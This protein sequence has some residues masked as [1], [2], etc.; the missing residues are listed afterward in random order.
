MKH[1]TVNHKNRFTYFFVRDEG[2]PTQSYVMAKLDSGP[3]RLEHCTV[4]LTNDT[5]AR[6]NSNAGPLTS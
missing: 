4:L 5:S 1:C 3:R 2:M 6:D